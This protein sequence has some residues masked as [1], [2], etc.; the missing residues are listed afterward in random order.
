M[1]PIDSFN[2][3]EYVHAWHTY[4]P[5]LNNPAPVGSVQIWSHFDPRLDDRPGG[6]AVPLC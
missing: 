5:M 4:F 6:L 2:G 1:F 3:L